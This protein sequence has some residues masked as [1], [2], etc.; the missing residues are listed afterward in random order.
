MKTIPIFLVD[1]FTAEPFR[2]NPAGVV[3]LEE[4]AGATW[5]QQVA[6]E[7]NQA[8]TAFIVPQDNNEFGLRWFTP[9]IEVELCGHATLASA[10]I[11]WRLHKVPKEAPIVFNTLSGQLTCIRVE[12]KIQMNFPAK[13]VSPCKEPYGLLA[14][15][16]LLEANIFSNGMD[17]LVEVKD[18]AT[19]RSMQPIYA[20]LAEVKCR[21][22]IVTARSS[23]S[24]YDFVSRFFAPASGINED[25]VT[26]SAHC[27]LGP[28][29]S[30]RLDK[31]SLVG[32]QA[33]PRGGVVEVDTLSDRVN[34]RGHAV[35]F[36][37]GELR[38]E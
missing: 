27:A 8:E 20:A 10:H 7:M 21:G 25:S 33:S 32:Y 23:T 18:E 24:G 26:G 37:K 3:L 13:V 11:L 35:T 29:W 12:N 4:Q 17:Y 28:F 34:L 22:V 19:V 5:M 6:S 38:G 2:G 14:A 16:Q 1:A 31:L 36:L 30:Q 15:L 9:T